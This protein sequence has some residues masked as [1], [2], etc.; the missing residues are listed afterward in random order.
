VQICAGDG[1]RE[2]CK[3]RVPL[4]AVRHPR[5]AFHIRQSIGVGI[6]H[7]LALTTRR[8]KVLAPL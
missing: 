4:H 5:N 3:R 2:R 6:D 8:V 7:A 1:M